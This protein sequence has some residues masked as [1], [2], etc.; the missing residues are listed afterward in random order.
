MRKLIKFCT[1]LIVHIIAFV[2]IAWIFLGMTPTETYQKFVYRM[3]SIRSGTSTFAS[4]LSKTGA[5][6]GR[7]ANQHLGEAAERIDGRDPYERQNSIIDQKVRSDFG[8]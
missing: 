7:V 1:W 5:S 8:K 3:H 4:D 2:V 6:M